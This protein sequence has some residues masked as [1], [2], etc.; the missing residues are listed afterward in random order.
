MASF[1]KYS[2]YNENTSFS[3]VVFG[4]ESPILEVELNEMQQIMHTKLVLAL[5]AIL[6]DKSSLT[7]LSSDSVTFSQVDGK[8]YVTLKNCIALAKNGWVAYIDEATVEV[9]ATNKR[10]FI[11]LLEVTK[12]HN[13]TLNAYGNVKGIAVANTMLDSRFPIETSKRKIITFELR[14]KDG[15]PNDS[16]STKYIAVGDFKSAT[17]T[18]EKITTNRID[19]LESKVNALMSN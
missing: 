13:D 19:I 12:S 17:N 7:P 4:A 5:H 15:I 2:N 8:N 9:D 14:S 16:D 3:S 18:F 11:A 6:G 10:V 1:D